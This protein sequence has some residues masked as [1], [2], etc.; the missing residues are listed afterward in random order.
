MTPMSFGR[1]GL[2]TPVLLSCLWGVASAATLSVGPDK[3]YKTPCAAFEAASKGSIIEIDATGN[4]DGDV[5]EI[6]QDR[7]TIRGIGPGRAWIDAAGRNAQDK[8]TWVIH[9]SN[10]TIENVELSGSHVPD[11]NGA[12]IRMEGHN[13]TL[14]NCAFHDNETAILTGE[15]PAG[16][17]LIEYSEFGNNGWRY[18]GGQS[19]SMYIGHV[20]KFTLQF[21][22]SHHTQVG[23][24]VKTRAA[25]NFIL[26]NRL[27]D[28]V[29]G[30][31]SYEV[32]IPNGGNSYL[33]GNVLQKG[34]HADN[35]NL[36]SYRVE[37]PD[38]RNPGTHLYV[39]NNTFVTNTPPRD[40]WFLILDASVSTPAII[41]NNIFW[42]PL[43]VTNQPNAILAANL[44]NTDPQF[45]DPAK[46]DYRL[47]SGSP[48]I[49]AGA[50][51]DPALRGGF[52]VQAVSEYVHPACGAQR[53]AAGPIDIGAFEFGGARSPAPECTPPESALNLHVNVSGVVGSTEMEAELL[54]NRPAPPG[55]G[56]A[57]LS[58]S[59]PKLLT[60]PAR[61]T[62]SAGENSIV[63]PITAGIAPSRTL[64]TVTASAGPMKRTCS[65]AVGVSKKD[66]RADAR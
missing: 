12:A 39:F 11:K 56:M 35:P 1:I 53:P 15:D 49:D 36:V 20:N 45:V 18:S 21:S 34:A 9:G 22:Y 2:L 62:I 30:G 64:V 41:Q 51:P 7:L 38:S 48:A 50:T 6:T 4:Y 8:G 23:H 57:L 10:T 37:G 28:E 47:R 26:Y 59:N 55:G 13:L 17:I 42:G 33:I 32:N 31:A 43:G 63:V 44:V 3:K 58:S 25:N 66:R 61:V 60:V 40:A 19:H 14:R 46:F 27:T 5:C 29:D 16:E 24:L 52:S 65:F 54:L